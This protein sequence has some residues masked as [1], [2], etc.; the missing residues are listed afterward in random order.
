MHP[1]YEKEPEMFVSFNDAAKYAREASKKEEQS[2]VLI[3]GIDWWVVGRPDQVDFYRQ[4]P[5][6][7]E[8]YWGERLIADY[9]DEL[10]DAQIADTNGETPNGGLMPS[11]DDLPFPADQVDWER[12]NDEGWFYEDSDD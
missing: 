11:P 1:Y 7:V 4:S 5:E 6:S 2:I 8:R 3:R 9:E 12:S 10:H